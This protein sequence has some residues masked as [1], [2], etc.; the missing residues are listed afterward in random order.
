MRIFKLP[1]KSLL[2]S[3]VMLG[4]ATLM[5]SQQADAQSS[6]DYAPMAKFTK[7]LTVLDDGRPQVAYDTVREGA[8]GFLGS[9]QNYLSKRD[10]STWSENDQLA[11]WLNV[12]NLLVVKAI[13]E[14]T[15]SSKIKSEVGTFAE[16]GSLWTKPRITISGQPMSIAD[17]EAKALAISTDPNVIYGL[18]QGVKGAPALASAPFDGTKVQTQLATLGKNFVNS[19]DVV[20]AKSSKIKISSYYEWFQPSL[21]DNNNDALI[22]H[23]NQHASG[24]LAGRLSAGQNISFG[25]MSYKVDQYVV[26][27]AQNQRVYSSNGAPAPRGYG[28]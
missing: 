11:Y 19:K 23:L 2:L 8:L 27:S 1:L 6:N 21:F 5:T 10:I 13:A 7:Q 16:R 22:A 26:P 18:Y 20:S 12:Q 3:A 4:S 14:D 25:K 24:K 15:K 28:S 17:V 9:Y